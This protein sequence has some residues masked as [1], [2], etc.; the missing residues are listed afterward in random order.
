MPCATATIPGVFRDAN[1]DACFGEQLVIGSLQGYALTFTSAA[2]IE[3]FLPAGGTPGSLT[4][5]Q[6]DPTGDTGAGV[7]AGQVLAFALNLGFANCNL[8][9]F[10]SNFGSLKI[11][12]GPF[13]GYTVENL[14]AVAT[15]V[16]GGDLALLPEGITISDLNDAVDAINNNFDDGHNNGFLV[17]PDCD[18]EEQLPDV[19]DLGDLEVCYPTEALNP[20][21]RLTEIA[22][23]GATVDAEDTPDTLNQDE[24]DDGVIFFNAP[25]TPCEVESVQVEVTAGANYT[26]F[27]DSAGVLY[28]N[29]WKDGNLDCDFC[30]VLCDGNGRRSGS[31]RTPSSLPAC[32]VLVQ[33]SGRDRSRPRTT[34]GCAS[35]CRK[36][37]SR[38]ARRRRRWTWAKWKITSSAICSSRSNSWAA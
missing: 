3:A 8:A 25:W 23:L 1:F 18:V 11:F 28:L 15:S 17:D 29:A 14:F 20:A 34:G 36:F 5:S 33:R 12:S 32:T 19:W 10:C 13:A 24:G 6:T 30:D 37:R 26:A 22:W 7:F 16:L 38:A 31:F 4:S 2:A 27:T 35:A 21:H 9:G